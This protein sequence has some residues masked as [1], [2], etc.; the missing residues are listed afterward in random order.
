MQSARSGGTCRTRW[1]LWSRGPAER[2][3]CDNCK[4]KGTTT[5]CC[6]VH[7]WGIIRSAMAVS[8]YTS[9]ILCSLFNASMQNAKLMLLCDG[10]PQDKSAALGGPLLAVDRM[11]NHLAVPLSPKHALELLQRITGQAPESQIQA[12]RDDTVTQAAIMTTALALA[13]QVA[14]TWQ[15]R[16]AGMQQ[17]LFLVKWACRSG[18]WSR[19]LC[20]IASFHLSNIMLL[21]AYHCISVP[22][23]QHCLCLLSSQQ[24]A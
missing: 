24:Y 12:F 6:D 18:S 19:T 13:L 11:Q 1:L 2:D 20:M 9:C 23:R 22:N 14:G 15:D 8:H 17:A 16:N 7:A 5:C 10:F 3:F 21:N 4:Y